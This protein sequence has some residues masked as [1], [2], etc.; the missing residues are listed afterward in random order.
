MVKTNK[1]KAKYLQR[2]FS[3]YNLIYLEEVKTLHFASVHRGKQ[4]DMLLKQVT[5]VSFQL[6]A[7]KLQFVPKF[8]VN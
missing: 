7:N 8:K 3:W 5:I 6:I 1:V 4:Q 2:N